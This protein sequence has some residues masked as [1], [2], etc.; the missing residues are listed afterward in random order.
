VALAS[1]MICEPPILILDE[2]DSFLDEKGRRA[3]LN[4]EELI[5]KRNPEMIIIRVTQ[6]LSVARRYSFRMLSGRSLL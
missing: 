5:R 3:L 6:Y 1:V 4:E 2:P